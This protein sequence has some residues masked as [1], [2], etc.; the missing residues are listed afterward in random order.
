MRRKKRKGKI[1][2]KGVK[3]IEAFLQNLNVHY[4][5]EYRFS[6]CR[7]KL[8][9]PF[10]FVIFKNDIF[11]GAIEYNGIQ[12]YQKIRRFSGRKG[13]KKQQL[14]DLIK[15]DYCSQNKIPLLIISYLQEENIEELCKDFLNTIV[16]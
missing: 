3:K 15:I 4:T 16:D 10:D 7:D 11:C 5:K 6:D 2:S 8:P 13:F 9:L 1:V 12:H 14:H